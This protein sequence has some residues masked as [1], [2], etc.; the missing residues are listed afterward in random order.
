MKKIMKNFLLPLLLVFMLFSAASC[1]LRTTGTSPEPTPGAQPLPAAGSQYTMKNYHI[2]ARPTDPVCADLN[3]DGFNDIAV[4]LKKQALAVLLN[5]RSGGFAAPATY[6]TFPHNTSLTAAD[7]DGD[8]DLDLIPLTELK[9]GP[10]FLNDGRGTFSRHDLDIQALLYSWHIESHDLN[11]D[12]LPDLVITSLQKPFISLV[13]NRGG[14]QFATHR[15]NLMPGIEEPRHR[16]DA[17]A[18]PDTTPAVGATDRKVIGKEK[19]PAEAVKKP[20][21]EKPASPNREDLRSVPPSE[22][23]ITLS[24]DQLKQMEDASPGSGKYIPGSQKWRYARRIK[25]LDN[26]FKDAV[27]T[28]MNGDGHPDILSPSYVFDSI[29]FGMNNGKGE[30]DFVSVPVEPELPYELGYALSSIAV[31]RYPDRK[32]PDVAVSSERDGNI[33]LFENREGTLIQKGRLETRRKVP[34]RIVSDDLNGDSLPDIVVAFAAELPVEK[35][36]MI[37][38]WLNSR[39]GFFLKETLQSEGQGIYLDTCRFSP[40]E[41]PSIIISNVHEESLTIFSPIHSSSGK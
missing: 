17:T 1:A 32:L 22:E 15:I 10:V 27:I 25:A 2:G 9:V 19:S 3:S 39:E 24:P 31:L 11:G 40:E 34:V 21:A 16:P 38:V 30:F 8:G 23:V 5:N 35:R 20:G 7:I 33:Y 37:Q 14:L 29:F 13:M 12:A 18:S 26:G 36:S 4:A 28:D 6:A 41:H